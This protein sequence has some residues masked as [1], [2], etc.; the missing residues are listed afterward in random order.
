MDNGPWT[1]DHGHW[2]M[3]PVEDEEHRTWLRAGAPRAETL[4]APPVLPADLVER[5]RDLRI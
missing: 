5:V 2:T 4:H 1:M 3:D